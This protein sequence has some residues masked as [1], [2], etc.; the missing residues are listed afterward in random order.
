MDIKQLRQGVSALTV[1]INHSGLLLGAID[2]QTDDLDFNKGI[3]YLKKDQ[4]RGNF[5]LII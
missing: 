3:D 5:L 4:I 2:R 1:V